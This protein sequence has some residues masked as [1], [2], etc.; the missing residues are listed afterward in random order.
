MG[1]PSRNHAGWRVVAAP[2]IVILGQPGSPF[3]LVIA[4][5]TAALHRHHHAAAAGSCAS[6]DAAHATRSGASGCGATHASRGRPRASATAGTKPATAVDQPA[7]ADS[8]STEAAWSAA[9]Q[10]ATA[11]DAAAVIA[12]QR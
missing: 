4:A 11:A 7:T 10:C 8:A 6:D 5:L 9:G 12:G 2:H 3:P 1:A